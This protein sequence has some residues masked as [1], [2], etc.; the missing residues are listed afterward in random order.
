[1][2]HSASLLW[3]LE[4]GSCE[5]FVLTGLKPLPSGFQPPK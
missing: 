1:L 5:L 2:S 3:F 4:K